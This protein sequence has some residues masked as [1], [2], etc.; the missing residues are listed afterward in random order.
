MMHVQPFVCVLTSMVINLLHI[1]FHSYTHARRSHCG[2]AHAILVQTAA[3]ALRLVLIL[4][5]RR[6][7]AESTTSHPEGL[8]PCPRS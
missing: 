2:H 4:N 6:D 5:L 1:I 3:Q 8:L 7:A